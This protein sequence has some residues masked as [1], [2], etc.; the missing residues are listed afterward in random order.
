MLATQIRCRDSQGR[1]QPLPSIYGPVKTWTM[2]NKF[3]QAAPYRLKPQFDSLICQV[4]A[5]NKNDWGP[6]SP[7]S[8]F[9][10][11]NECPKKAAP[12]VIK[13]PARCYNHCRRTGCNGA[14]KKIRTRYTYPLHY[15]STADYWANIYS[16]SVSSACCRWKLCACQKPRY[17]IK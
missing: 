13:K 6:W 9:G 15:R 16:R 7:A 2:H 17:Y 1:Y 5:Q 3:L 11:F 10:S 12:V 4:R 14:C 8:N